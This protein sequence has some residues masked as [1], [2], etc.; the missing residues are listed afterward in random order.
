MAIQISK[1]STQ[2]S[3]ALPCYD[4]AGGGESRA[5][6]YV[7]VSDRE[8]WVGYKMSCDN[9]WGVREHRGYVHTFSV[10]NNFTP[11]GYNDLLSRPGLQMLVERLIDECEEVY[12]GS[13]YKMR[14][15]LEGEEVKIAIA[16][17]CEEE[18]YDCESLEP[19]DAGMYL[20]DGTYEALT[21]N[22]GTHEEIAER[23]VVEARKDG[24]Y[25]SAVDV[26]SQLDKMA[27]EA[28]ED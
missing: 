15:S 10:P 19:W 4:T 2:S 3:D 26:E 24:I 7:D 1:L 6:L 18:I 9:S 8:M 5:Y 11:S 13:N 27:E 21:A 16:R 23:I 12:D 20:Q 25:L 14:I 17:Y 28:S 22:G